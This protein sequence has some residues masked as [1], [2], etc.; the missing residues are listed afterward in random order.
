MLIILFLQDGPV[1]WRNAKSC[2]TGSWHWAACFQ[3]NTAD[4]YKNYKCFFGLNVFVPVVMVWND[5]YKALYTLR[6]LVSQR[7]VVTLLAAHFVITSLVRFVL[8][9]IVLMNKLYFSYIIL[10]SCAR[11]THTHIHGH[12]HIHW[13]SHIHSLHHILLCNICPVF[14]SYIPFS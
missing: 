1:Q 2:K 8:V 7:T 9:V 4:S 3:V 11:Y 14:V 6:C 12:S 13:H 5:S 10:S